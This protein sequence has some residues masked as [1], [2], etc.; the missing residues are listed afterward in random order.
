MHKK[1][2]FKHSIETYIKLTVYFNSFKLKWLCINQS[3]YKEYNLENN[4][5]NFLVISLQNVYKALT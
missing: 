4:S 2:L 1:F 3:H 5:F